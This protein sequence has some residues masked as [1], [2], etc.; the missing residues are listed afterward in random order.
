MRRT[1]TAAREGSTAGGRAYAARPSRF[2]LALGLGLAVLI[3]LE[4]RIDYAGAA[5]VTPPH[6]AVGLALALPLVWRRVAPVPVGLGVVT[7]FMLQPEL[8][9]PTPNTAG[10]ALCLV[11]AVGALALYPRSWTTA[12]VCGAAATV[13]GILGA[14]LDP[15]PKGLEAVST[16]LTV[17]GV[18]G[19]GALLRRQTE[20]ARRSEAVIVTERLDA[21]RR[22]RE[23]VAQE[24]G[25]IAR[26]L[27]DVVSH[28]MGVVVLQ[29][30]GGR[31]VLD[32]DSDRARVAFD[33]IERVSADCL[34]E[35]RLM[36]D[37]LRLEADQAPTDPPQ[38]GL[39]RLGDLVDEMR[40]AGVVVVAEVVGPAVELPV[41]LDV[42]AYRILQ[43]ALTNV[44]QHAPGA[45][46]AVTVAYAD[47]AVVLEVVDDGPPI[48]RPTPGHGL[49]GMRERVEL[50]D[51]ELRWEAPASGGFR[52]H[53]RLPLTPVPA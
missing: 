1:P 7:L 21:E 26:E 22:S 47:D 51:G 39:G 35:M 27:H 50:Y 23:L 31:R 34:R 5:D 49:V 41:G 30:R 38:P 4:Y 48:P 16:S 29:A 45:T 46:A 10:A 9:R 28:G 24:R 6:V 2:D 36:L 42:S 8:L 13:L 25:R 14:W 20:R 33:E 15:D 12:I 17:A 44:A 11:V 32:V 19:A 52:V 53:A 18:W 37:V 40:A 3:Q 43:E